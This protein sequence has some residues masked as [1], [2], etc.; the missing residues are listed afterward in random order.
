ML[1]QLQSP[2]MRLPRELRNE[3]YKLVLVRRFSIT[4]L[5]KNHLA[6]VLACWQTNNEAL[7]I[8]YRYNNFL[9]SCNGT[10]G[11][12]MRDRP[13]ILENCLNCFR[14]GKPYL[15]MTHSEHDLLRLC[16]IGNERRQ[17]LYHAKLSVRYSIEH[18]SAALFFMLSHCHHLSLTISMSAE[19][20]E[21]IYNDGMMRLVHGIPRERIELVMLP[22][23]C[24]EHKRTHP[25]QIP[26]AQLQRSRYATLLMNV[27]AQLTSPCPGFCAFHG[28]DGVAKAQSSRFK[29]RIEFAECCMYTLSL[30]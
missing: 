15:E 10:W 18:P 20:L 29:V 14:E 26:G 21:A 5:L 28:P 12:L 24:Q 1:P 6:L 30:R 22:R 2:L 8:F 4:L 3:I 11:D 25:Q 23:R 19:K 16:N 13:L 7:P 27:R 9:L 17:L